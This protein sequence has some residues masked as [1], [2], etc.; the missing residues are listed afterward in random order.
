MV[1]TLHTDDDDYDEYDKQVAAIK[2]KNHI[3][4]CCIAR[5]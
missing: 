2:L 1:N 5:T 4:N 3:I